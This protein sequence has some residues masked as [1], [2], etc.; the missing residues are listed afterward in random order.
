MD[1][2]TPSLS[3]YANP[4][5]NTLLD[6]YN[7]QFPVANNY[8]L[9]SDAMICNNSVSNNC[10]TNNLT[11]T[12][13][14]FD[15]TWVAISASIDNQFNTNI[16]MYDFNSY[17][18]QYRI[19]FCA[20][21]PTSSSVIHDITGTYHQNVTYGYSSRMSIA[22]NKLVFNIYFSTN[23]CRVRNITNVLT[24]YTTGYLKIVFY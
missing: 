2:Y 7:P 20:T 19:Y 10:I 15:S 24:T 11:I 6:L 9:F 1:S 18:P 3:T 8:N 14:K 16:I 4:T 21:T 5:Y 22:S 13:P 17:I 12:Q 23:I